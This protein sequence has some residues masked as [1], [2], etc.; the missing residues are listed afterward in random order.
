[1]ELSPSKTSHGRLC[2][3]KFTNDRDSD[4]TSLEQRDT[5]TLK[6]SICLRPGNCLCK[7][8]SDAAMEPKDQRGSNIIARMAITHVL[9]SLK[10]RCHVR[11]KGELAPCSLLPNT[12]TT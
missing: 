12:T 1:M 10:G 6:G 5:R 8:N 3:S 7:F 11:S 4:V 9:S 2:S